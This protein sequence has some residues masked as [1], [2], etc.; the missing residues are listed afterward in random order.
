MNCGTLHPHVA[1]P[2]HRLL[3]FCLCFSAMA[4]LASSVA[5]LS[6]LSILFVL[7]SPAAALGFLPVQAA[8]M[9]G[10]STASN[11]V[12]AGV[13]V[14]GYNH[15]MGTFTSSNYMCRAPT[16]ERADLLLGTATS[17]NPT[18]CQAVDGTGAATNLTSTVRAGYGATVL[19][20]A[21]REVCNGDLFA[22]VCV[23]SHVLC[24]SDQLVCAAMYCSG[25]AWPCYL[26]R[27]SCLPDHHV[28]SRRW[29]RKLRW[30]A[31]PPSR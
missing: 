3:C 25:Y 9:L 1:V 24:P 23:Y 21:R 22:R 12:L 7:V 2:I 15:V 17:E 27:W 11:T 8:M 20:L 13:E 31:T 10:G 6:T 30:L 14:V 5:V 18:T 29:Q 19:A 16:S 4:R 28:G 26:A